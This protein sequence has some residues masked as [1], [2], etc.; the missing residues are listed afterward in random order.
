MK[1][2]VRI[3]A[4]ILIIVLFTGCTANP[5]ST[6]N[7]IADPTTDPT[8]QT[9]GSGTVSIVDTIKND[10][11]GDVSGDWKVRRNRTVPDIGQ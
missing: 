7:A 1:Q 4:I 2:T 11:H 8:A 5:V 3:F 9:I 10:F 6:T